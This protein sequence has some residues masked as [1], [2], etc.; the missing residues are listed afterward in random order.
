MTTLIAPWTTKCTRAGAHTV[1][2]PNSKRYARGGGE[3]RREQ[4]GGQGDAPWQRGEEEKVNRHE[5]RARHHDRP[6]EQTRGAHASEEIAPKE[7]LLGEA[8]RD[9]EAP[10]DEPGLTRSEF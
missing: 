4:D 5:R 1:S 2:P 6:P 7:D 8:S 10:D 3:G 9:D